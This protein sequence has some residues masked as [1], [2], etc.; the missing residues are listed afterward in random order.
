MAKQSL[1]LQRRLRE[2]KKAFLLNVMRNSKIQGGSS[3]HTNM[4]GGVVGKLEE[5][6][7]AE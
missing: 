3:P 2:P 4:P 1:V 6:Q 5:S 7:Y